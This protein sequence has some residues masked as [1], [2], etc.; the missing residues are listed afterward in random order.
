MEPELLLSIGVWLLEPMM[1]LIDVMEKNP[2][3]RF[4]KDPPVLGT[5]FSMGDQSPPL[6]GPL[7]L[8]DTVKHIA[9]NYSRGASH[10]HAT[11]KHFCT[12]IACA[13]LCK[14]VCR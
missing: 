7:E 6:P 14:F 1:T 11:V 13:S 10:L 12:G 4:V 5:G 2:H 3:A 9:K 8:S